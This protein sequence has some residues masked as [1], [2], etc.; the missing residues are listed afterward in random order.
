MVFICIIVFVVMFISLFLL[1]IS[2]VVYPMREKLTHMSDN[3][4]MSRYYDFCLLEKTCVSWKDN[5][6]RKLLLNEM[7]RRKL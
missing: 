7:N 4:L 5:L 1:I 6:E 3:K 2:A